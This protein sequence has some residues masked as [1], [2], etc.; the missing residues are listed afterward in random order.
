MLA[1]ILAALA[2]AIWLYLL[3]GRGGF[4]LSSAARRLPAP[5]RCRAGPG[6]RSPSSSR[7]AMRPK[8][9]AACIGSLLRQDYPGEWS[10]VLVDDGSQRRHRRHRAAGPPRRSAR[11]GAARGRDRPPAPGRLDRQAVGGAAGHRGGASAARARLSAALGRRHRLCARRA[12]LPGGARAGRRTGAHL[13]D[14]QAAL[15]EPGR[16]RPDPG[17]HLL[18]S[19]ALPVRAGSTAPQA[20]TAGAAGGCML[21]R[22]DT[23]RAGRRHRGDPQCLDRRLRVGGHPQG[24]RPDLAR[25]HA[26][27]RTASA[28]Y[29]GFEDIRRMVARSA[30][31]QLRYSPLDLAG[32]ARRH[33]AD[34]SGAAA[35]GACSAPAGRA[36]S[37][38]RPGS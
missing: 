13:A 2:L 3:L 37:G 16:A 5:A 30:Y 34:L 4:W 35:D 24:A 33:G 9:S 10:I 1:Q 20:A 6:R 18:L 26:A 38:S 8:A 14:G 12:L 32:R 28:A 22:A 29:P 36:R 27:R 17:L 7:R 19:D 23:L 15:R 11:R 31:A 21:V 25:P